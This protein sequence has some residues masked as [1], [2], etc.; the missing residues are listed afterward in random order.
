MKGKEKKENRTVKLSGCYADGALTVLRWPHS[1][2]LPAEL[3]HA[4][5]QAPCPRPQLSGAS[6]VAPESLRLA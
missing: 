5:S 6:Q 2:N 3:L 1:P 4:H